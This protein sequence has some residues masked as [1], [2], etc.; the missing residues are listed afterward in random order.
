MAKKLNA[1][2]DEKNF[3]LAVQNLNVRIVAGRFESA[4]KRLSQ[5]IFTSQFLLGKI[6]TRLKHMNVGIAFMTV[7]VLFARESIPKYHKL[8]ELLD[9]IISIGKCLCTRSPNDIGVLL[10]A[11]GSHWEH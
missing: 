7:Y 3:V 8:W 2:K 4:A 10:G 1:D 5:V 6:P 9:T 11:P